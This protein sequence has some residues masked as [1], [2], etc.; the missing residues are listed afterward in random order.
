M[1]V[2]SDFKCTHHAC[3]YLYDIHKCRVYVFTVPMTYTVHGITIGGHGA[4]PM[5]SR[6]PPLQQHTQEQS[7]SEMGYHEQS[8]PSED[9]LRRWEEEK[10]AIR[11]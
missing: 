1:L 8:G 2:S 5:E 7:E 9:M 6:P 10:E 4:I 3:S 11:R